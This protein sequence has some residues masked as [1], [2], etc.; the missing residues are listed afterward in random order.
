VCVCIHIENLC[1]SRALETFKC[2]PEEWGVNVQPLSGSPANF[3]V[4]LSLSSLSRSLSLARSLSLYL[5]LSLLPPFLLPSLSSSVP[6]S[7][8]YLVHYLRSAL[9][10]AL[11]I[12]PRQSVSSLKVVC[13]QILLVERLACDS[14]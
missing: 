3:Q 8:V 9:V 6:L 7:L 1:R 4:V 12:S 11:L 13:Y 10:A 2:N 5:S 14:S